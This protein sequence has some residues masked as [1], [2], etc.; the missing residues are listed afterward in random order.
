MN[1]GPEGLS[2]R[3][4]LIKLAFGAEQQSNVMHI[5]KAILSLWLPFSNDIDTNYKK[6]TKMSII[7]S[8]DDVHVW[9]HIMKFLYGTTFLV[10]ISIQASASLFSVE[11][12][13][14]QYVITYFNWSHVLHVLLI[15]NYCYCHFVLLFLLFVAPLHPWRRAHAR[16]GVVI[17]TS[18]RRYRPLLGEYCFPRA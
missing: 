18:L 3:I 6:P 2:Y 10:L 5:Q 11:V 9:C 12:L 8:P 16:G 14:Q 1:K 4:F 15:Y 13:K 7:H 17:S